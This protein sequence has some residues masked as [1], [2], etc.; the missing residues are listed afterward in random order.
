[1]KQTTVKEPQKIKESRL[2]VISAAVILAIIGLNELLL[3]GDFSST[4]VD[5]LL[6]VPF[7]CCLLRSVRPRLKGRLIL[8]SFLLLLCGFEQMVCFFWDYGSL[9]PRGESAYRMLRRSLHYGKVFL[10]FAVGAA[11]YCVL[12]ALACWLGQLMKKRI[13]QRDRTL[14]RVKVACLTTALVMSAFYVVW[15]NNA[16]EVSYYTYETGRYTSGTPFRIVQVTD[17]HNKAFGA[18]SRYLVDVIR[19]A[20]PDI[21]VMTGDLVD[22]NRTD[23]PFGIRFMQQA[24]E[25]AP[26]YFVCGNHEQGLP[27]EEYDALIDGIEASGCAVMQNEWVSLNCGTFDCNLIGLR[28]ARLTDGTLDEIMPQNGDLNILLAHAPDYLDYYAARDIDLVFAG[29][30]HGGQFRIPFV[31]GV[32]APGQGFWPKYTDGVY[33]QGNT[34]MVVSR[35]LGNSVIPVRLNNRPEIVVVDLV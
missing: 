32:Y 31:G 9:L 20:N 11:G 5:E 8:P 18:D 33:R 24:A 17:L 35:G 15:E 23:I 21:I 1:M 22:R 29:H 7:L 6:T 12:N 25:I 19:R 3:S 14:L 16:I 13:S 26:T 27:K 30:A 34:T 28:F 10:I 2:P 4:Y